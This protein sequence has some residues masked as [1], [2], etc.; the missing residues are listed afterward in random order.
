M[1][2]PLDLH[3]SSRLRT[4]RT[5][6][7]MTQT[8]LSELIGVARQQINKY[9]SGANRIPASRLY[10]IAQILGKPVSNFFEEFVDDKY[11]NFD[12]QDEK[13]CEESEEIN[14]K[15]ITNLIKNFSKISDSEIRRNIIELLNSI[16][17]MRE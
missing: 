4:I 2:T 14:N 5:M 16:V 3:I 17:R 10:E 13:S 8:E 12:F 6:S 15:E 11:Y 7:G 1:K 9:E